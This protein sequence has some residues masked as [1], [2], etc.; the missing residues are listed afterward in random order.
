MFYLWKGVCMSKKADVWAD[1]TPEDLI[2]KM[3]ERTDA[4]GVLY[5][6]SFF[7]PSFF[8]DEHRDEISLRCVMG[9]ELPGDCF[10]VLQQFDQLRGA[11]DAIAMQ[12]DADGYLD[13]AAYAALTEAQKEVVDTYL[14]GFDSD[15]AFDMDR[16]RDIS[17]RI[18][19]VDE[20][21]ELCRKVAAGAELDT[22]SEDYLR[23]YL[24]ETVS[25][26]ERAYYSRFHAARIAECR[27]K[28]GDQPFAYRTVMQVLRYHKLLTLQAPESILNREASA[29]AA[30][31]ALFRWCKKYE[32]V[33]NAVRHHFDR[34]ERMSDEEL[35]ALHRPGKNANSRKS[36]VPLFV[37]LIL[38]QHSDS[39]HPLKQQE[40]IAYLADEPYEVVIE[41][42]ALSRVIHN[43]KDSQLGIYTDKHRGTWHMGGLPEET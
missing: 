3:F 7:L 14:R 8:S 17:E 40:I 22:Q 32:Y 29:L 4:D 35:D 39:E 6:P 10:S 25:A 13:D 24:S 18:D 38:M 5:M 16:I 31:F 20:I 2:E 28:L 41:R 34:L 12:C 15:E 21:R 43:L 37:Y 33:D 27:R 23:S 42:K 36:L 11:L 9:W 19:T 30:A 26:E 1:L